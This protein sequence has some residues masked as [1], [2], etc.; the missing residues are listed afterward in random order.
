MYTARVRRLVHRQA[1]WISLHRSQSTKVQ[2]A[3]AADT[4]K[5]KRICANGSNPNFGA[6]PVLGPPNFQA[7]VEIFLVDAYG[8]G[9]WYIF[10]TSG[11][12]IPMGFVRFATGRD[13]ADIAL[14]TIFGSVNAAQPVI[15]VRAVVNNQGQPVVP[16]HVDH[17]L[18]TDGF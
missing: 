4:K 10:D 9:R 16:K 2:A 17:A 7:Y 15:N 5:P 14:T 3:K 8:I 6:N 18:S 13:A 1:P 12:A 11:N